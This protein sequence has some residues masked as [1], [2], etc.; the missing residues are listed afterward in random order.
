MKKELKGIKIFLIIYGGA[1]AAISLVMTIMSG[2]FWIMSSD[3]IAITLMTFM[4]ILLF[5]GL[6]FLFFG[7]YI[8]KIKVKRSLLHLIIS[9]SS[10]LWYIL[11]IICLPHRNS[12][13]DVNH[14]DLFG[15]VFTIIPFTFA[16]AY[17]AIFI[18]PELIIWRKL[19]KF[20]RQNNTEENN[21]AT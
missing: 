15:V 20:E 7:I 13:L 9:I 5:I 2:V 8:T 11:F 21:N 12:L 10:I 16:T 19:R 6:A 4:P 1:M 17:S 3:V 18:V 14:P